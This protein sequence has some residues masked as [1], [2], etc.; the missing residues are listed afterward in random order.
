MDA[1]NAELINESLAQLWDFGNPSASGERFIVFRER[2]AKAGLDELA[3]LTRT[4]IARSLGLGRKFD[5]GFAMIDSIMQEYPE[6][7]GELKVRLVLERGRLLNSSGK[8]VESAPEF[9]SAWEE[10]RC[11]GL[12]GLAVDAAHMLGIVLDGLDGM[13]W[14]E[15]ALTLAVGSDQ[16]SANKWRGSLLNNMGWAYHEAENY[17]RAMELFEQALE[18]RVEGGKPERIRI[19]RWCVGRCFRSLGKFDVALSIQRSLENDPE[20]D[21]YVFEELGECLLAQ[22]HS[23]DAKPN[24]TKAHKML[25]QDPWLVANEAGRLNRL[26]ELGDV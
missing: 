5:E 14:N 8:K 18:L 26:K 22:G 9:V 20:A 11:S 12:D 13:D 2:A 25:S 15:R 21:G 10:A 6:A 23:N 19:A 3:A 4:Q 7:S 24:F 17:Q 1:T 16:P